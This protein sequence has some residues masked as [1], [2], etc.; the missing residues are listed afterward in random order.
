MKRV[1]VASVVT[2][3]AFGGC[4]DKDTDPQV[5]PLKAQAAGLRAKLLAAQ[6]LLPAAGKESVMPCVADAAPPMLRTLDERL[7]IAAAS[8]QEL[9]KRDR[10][11]ASGL[12]SSIL[13]VPTDSYLDVLGFTVQVRPDGAMPK[14]LTAT[15]A[16][17]GWSW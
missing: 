10:A 5:A 13:A 17:K 1:V 9:G 12:S 15:A 6:N 2:L 8:N 16:V 11:Q 3:V 4:G 14:Q 7:L